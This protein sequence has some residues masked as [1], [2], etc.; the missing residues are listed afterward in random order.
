MT[1]V[2][3]ARYDTVV[4]LTVRSIVAGIL[5]G[6]LFGA[7][8]AYLGLRVGLTVSTSIPIAV[9]TVALF[10]LMKKRAS[11]VILEANLSQTIGSAS[12]S[13]A[14]GTIFT[15]P[16]L[17][18]WGM[19]PP[20]WQIAILALLGG[21][22]G[23]AAMVPLRRLLIVRSAHELPYPEGT[24]CA[25]VLK[26]TTSAA[27]GGRWIF[28]GL[29]VGAAIKL[30]LGAFVLLPSELTMLLPVLPKAELALEVAPALLAVGYILGYRQSAIMVSGSLISAIVLTPL[31]A[32]VGAGLTAPLFPEMTTPIRDLSAGQIWGRYVRYIGA[33]AVAAAGIVAVARALPTMWTSFAAV[34]RGLRRD[35]GVD[36]Q[37][38]EAVPRTDRDI[39][40]WIVVLVP[41]LVVITL[42]AAP[43]IFAGDMVFAQRLVLA[44]GVAVFGVAFVVVSSRIVGLIGV[45]SNPTS[46]MTLVSLLGVSVVFV[47]LGWGGNPAAR[48]A[49]LTVGTVVAIAASKAGDISQDLKTGYLVGA[50]PS[51][52]Q[53][54][55][56]IGAAFACWA[57]AGTVLLLGKAFTFGSP[58]LPA[59]QATLMK[60]VIEGVLAGSLPWG[61]VGTGAGL[62][63]CAL[64][65]GLPGLA[66]AVGIYLPLGSLTPIFVGGIVRRMVDARR[67][68]KATESDSG[69]LASSGMIAG[70]GLAGVLI[71]FLVAVSGTPGTAFNRALASIRFA[72]RDFT[73]I[74][75][76]AAVI[77]GIAIVLAVCWLLYRA[78]RS[79]DIETKEPGD[80]NPAT[81]D[82]GT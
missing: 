17:F 43:D 16:A 50:T 41:L 79:G 36:L 63:V 70:E 13:L 64:L 18:M 44:I 14:S 8:N 61:L 49:I 59:P 23:I 54:G 45:S 60:T 7:A 12:S 15:I 78:G 71:A 69:V 2:P 39:P 66:F 29:A 73:W 21:L 9:L 19:A 20:F 52:Q 27:V 33:G 3:P 37:T 42:A 31:I 51:R 5:F 24:A 53:F 38:G 1:V 82:G 48:A 46:A 22:L 34:M 32:L 25:E 40:A 68:G 67:K 35:E 10:N 81:L 30:A 4:E 74:A 65:A 11:G 75:G 76:P 77:G 58:E 62:A 72:S 55:Q 26:A 6:V 47:L 80:P 57:V 56:F 28:I